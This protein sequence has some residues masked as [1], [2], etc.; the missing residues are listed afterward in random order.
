MRNAISNRSFWLM[1]LAS[2]GLNMNA[3]AL[4][5]F[6]S[7]TGTN[8]PVITGNDLSI[9][10]NQS[11]SVINWNSFD[12]ASNESVIFNM[13]SSDAVLN[14]IG[15]DVSS[16]INGRISGAGTIYLINPNGM[17]FGPSSQVSVGSLV[18]SSLSLSAD[19]FNNDNFSFTESGSNGRVENLG[20][21]FSQGQGGSI[22]L[23][24]HTVNNEGLIFSSEG[25]V[26]L[27]SGSAITMTFD[28][29]NLMQF[30]VT[31]LIE[32]NDNNI[33]SAVANTGQIQGINITLQAKSIDDVFDV[34]INQ[35]GVIQ[36][37][38]IV[39]ANGEVRL[40]SQ[41]GPIVIGD[42]STINIPA[43]DII[44]EELA[45][46]T[47]EPPADDTTPPTTPPSGPASFANNDGNTL[48]ANSASNS[49]DIEGVDAAIRLGLY[50]IDGSGIKLPEGHE[51]A[52][53]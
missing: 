10:V 27:A 48:N 47:P 13:N 9:T 36:A 31:G 20:R 24:G 38:G 46:A 8:A 50:G 40:T 25:K 30:D 17:V 11:R 16:S 53:F 45:S 12:V 18:A 51:E 6:E 19:D 44:I 21:I 7:S 33:D 28:N 39:V 32:T 37:N 3:H 35:D 5:S 49:G 2:T 52:L 26:A 34:A 4:P 23:I 29:D 41:G 14:L 42:N 1:L 22:A 43:E 15:G